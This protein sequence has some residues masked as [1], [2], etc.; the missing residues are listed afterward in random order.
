MVCVE[1]DADRVQDE[2]GQAL[3][4]GQP[5]RGLSSSKGTHYKEVGRARNLS[6][7]EGIQLGLRLPG[8]GY[9]LSS[10]GVF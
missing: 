10:G 4:L 6:M 1:E 2:S 5:T 3:D 7:L 8:G 9:L